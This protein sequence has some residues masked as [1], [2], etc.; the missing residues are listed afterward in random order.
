MNSDTKTPPPAGPEPAPS[1]ARP[2][3]PLLRWAVPAGVTAV[4]LGAGGIANLIPASAEEP[5][6]V[7]SVEQLLL[8]VQDSLQTSLSGTLVQRTDMGLP[9]LP[10][11]GSSD[12]A[13][14]VSGNHTLRLWYAG[15]KKVRVALLGSLEESDVI[16]NG[17]DTWVWSSRDKTVTH[18]VLPQ[19]P[20]G[21]SSPSPSELT[22][23]AAAKKILEAVDPTTVVSSAGP[24]KIAGER[25]YELVLSPKDSVSLI[26]R[27]RIAVEAAHHVPVRLQVFPRNDSNPAFEVAF[28]QISF[29]RPSDSHFRFTAPPGAKQQDLPSEAQSGQGAEQPP[30]LIGQGWT[31]VLAGRVSGDLLQKLLSGKLGEMAPGAAGSQSGSSGSVGA[32]ATDRVFQAFESVSGSWGKGRLLRTA[33]CSVLL[34]DDGR[35]YAGAVRPEALYR[36]AAGSLPSAGDGR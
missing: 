34:I 22:P 29:D 20:L 36:A 30:E 17:R 6:P 7:R 1:G 3:R 8:D 5:L 19:G 25:A 23:Q 10:Q 28:T 12:L 31:S 35:F 24:V 13:S 14:L 21:D 18:T 16:R 2:R 33:L 9:E 15:P 32:L 4:V 11:S 26:G 27:V